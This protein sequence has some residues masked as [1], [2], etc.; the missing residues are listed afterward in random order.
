MMVTPHSP[1]SSLMQGTSHTVIPPPN[2]EHCNI[3][4]TIHHVA[5]ITHHPK[6]H[7][8]RRSVGVTGNYVCWEEEA[9]AF[10]P[11]CN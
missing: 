9:A 4:P 3:A 6:G 11:G 10:L 2:A 8:T 7:P 5:P 1:D